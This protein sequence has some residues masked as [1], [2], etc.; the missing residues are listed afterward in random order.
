MPRKESSYD[1]RKAQ[2]NGQAISN[3]D[4]A[5]WKLWKP[6]DKDFQANVEREY[7]SIKYAVSQVNKQLDIAKVKVRLRN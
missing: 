6:K 7:L 3:Y 4:P 5:N 2:W 1:P